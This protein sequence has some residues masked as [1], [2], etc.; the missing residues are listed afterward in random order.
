MQDFRKLRVWHAGK[1]FCVAVYD[2]TRSFP[3]DERFGF[4]SQLRRS[5]RSI[6]ANIAEGCGYMGK[7]DSAR[8]YQMSLGSATESLSDMIIAQELESLSKADFDK[9]EELL[10]P[11]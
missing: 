1:D 7:N 6:C 5:A 9:L 11:T 4:T 3:A 10:L 2:V 8:F